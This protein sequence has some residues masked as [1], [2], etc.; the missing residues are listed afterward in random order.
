MK[1]AESESANRMLNLRSHLTEVINSHADNGL[2][3][4]ELIIVLAELIA[5]WSQVALGEQVKKDEVT[6]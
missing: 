1:V 6:E 5:A 2:S 4:A 3:Y